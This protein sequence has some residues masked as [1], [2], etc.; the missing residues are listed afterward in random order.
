MRAGT[1]G[2]RFGRRCV[3]CFLPLKRAPACARGI[4]FLF[5][6]SAIREK[7]MQPITIGD[8]KVTSIIERDGPWRAP[9]VMF[10]SATPEGLAQVLELVPDFTYERAR[11]LL[12]ITYQ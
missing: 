3:H 12:V 4:V 6:R 8:V 10:P 9:N 5:C 11:D 7:R 2:P 1:H